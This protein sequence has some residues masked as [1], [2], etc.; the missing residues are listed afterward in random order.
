MRGVEI[1]HCCWQ[2]ESHTP[3]LLHSLLAQAVHPASTY[4]ALTYSPALRVEPVAQGFYGVA[5]RGRGCGDDQ[6]RRREAR[7]VHLFVIRDKAR[8]RDTGE[9][10]QKFPDRFSRPRPGGARAHPVDSDMP[11]WIL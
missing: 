4:L 9:A 7:S 3:I 5:S 2:V 6:A 10:R 11:R 1:T 8:V